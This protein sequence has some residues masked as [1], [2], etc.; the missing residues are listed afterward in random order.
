MASDVHLVVVAADAGAARAAARRGQRLLEGLE[1]TWS[2]FL[3]GS[4]IDRLNRAAGVTIDIEPTTTVLL[5]VMRRAHRITE[6]RLDPTILPSLVAHG[7]ID[8]RTGRPDRSLAAMSAGSASSP[9]RAGLAEL[10]L[11]TARHQAQLPVGVALD[12]GAI[13]KGT[14]ADLVVVDLLDDLAA[15][16]ERAGVLVSVGGDLAFG[17][18]AP[19]GGWS[20]DIADPHTDP[21]TDTRSASHGCP[22]AARRQVGGAGGVATSSTR[23]HRWTGPDGAGRHH[24][25]DSATGRSSTTDLVSVTVVAGAGWLAEAA[26]TALLLAGSD[27]IAAEAARLSGLEEFSDGSIDYVAIPERPTDRAQAAA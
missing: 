2:R 16:D 19:E 27:G 6:G 12:P 26:A 7:Y 5:D 18:T 25:L 20:I 21:N 8:R 13:G 15:V 14:A 10:R 17:G 24:V 3:P 23:S 11:D 1:R 22:V 4:D 9:R